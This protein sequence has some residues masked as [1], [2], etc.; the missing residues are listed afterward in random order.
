MAKTITGS[1]CKIILI[2]NHHSRV[3]RLMNII[4]PLLLTTMHRS[5]LNRLKVARIRWLSL[6]RLTLKAVHWMVKC[7]W[8]SIAHLN[9]DKHFNCSSN[10]LQPAI[11]SQESYTRT[12]ILKFKSS[13]RQQS[14]NNLT[15]TTS[16]W[17]GNTTRR[18]CRRG[19]P[20]PGRRSPPTHKAH[21]A[22]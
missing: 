9:R 5:Q 1:E 19:R 3:T 7:E 2:R 4:M 11:E 22:L 14:S 17:W 12:Q 21:L 10:P 13:I 18:L 6:V 16:W 20:W 15:V 8:F